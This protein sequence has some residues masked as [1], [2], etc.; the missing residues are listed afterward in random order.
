M[1]LSHLVSPL[2]L[3]VLGMTVLVVEFLKSRFEWFVGKEAAL[4]I[5]LP[6]LLSV[7]AKVG[8]CTS[9][10]AMLAWPKLLVSSLL[11]GVFAQIA[12]DKLY[13]PVVKPL[14]MKLF[15]K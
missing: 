3:G 12:H 2:F 5:V 7:L 15:D 9:D 13:N 14:V 11:A 1:D 8:G 10:F 6:V 4:S